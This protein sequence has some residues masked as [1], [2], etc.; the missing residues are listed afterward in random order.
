MGVG[1]YS[2]LPASS[3][4]FSSSSRI[5]RLRSESDE[6]LIIEECGTKTSLAVSASSAGV[7][8]G[9]TRLSWRAWDYLV[10]EIQRKR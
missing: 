7:V 9:C 5:I 4:S 8:V 10:R 3:S 6:E 2:D 1:G